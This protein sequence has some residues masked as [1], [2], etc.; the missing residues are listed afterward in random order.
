MIFLMRSLT[1]LL[2]SIVTLQNNSEYEM[3]SICSKRSLFCYI[4]QCLMKKI[5]FFPVNKL[6]KIK[7]AAKHAF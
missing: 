2:I 7:S 6:K 4:N 5:G 3:N 1:F